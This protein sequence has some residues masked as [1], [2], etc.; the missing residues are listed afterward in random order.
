MTEIVKIYLLTGKGG[1]YRHLIRVENDVLVARNWVKYRTYIKGTFLVLS[2][3]SDNTA[4]EHHEI[5]N[6]SGTVEW[7]L[8]GGERW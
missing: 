8:K 3:D 4:L 2:Y 6:S 1:N 7:N 5:L